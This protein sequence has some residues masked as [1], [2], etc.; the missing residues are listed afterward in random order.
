MTDES[1]PVYREATDLAQVVQDEG[2]EL[3][4]AVIVEAD[5][6]GIA[7][8]GAGLLDR[9][10][11]SGSADDV[12]D[13]FGSTGGEMPDLNGVRGR[14]MDLQ[15]LNRGDSFVGPGSRRGS[16][17]TSP[18]IGIHRLHSLSSLHRAGQ[19]GPSP[20]IRLDRPNWSELSSNF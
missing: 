18:G 12:V 15:H 4:E 8:P 7:K 3:T 20:S 10:Q 11:V 17:S 6:Q 13:D 9:I 2:I 19:A 5:F 1:Q 16:G 14:P